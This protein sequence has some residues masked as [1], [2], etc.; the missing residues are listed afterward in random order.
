MLAGIREGFMKVF[1]LSLHTL[2]SRTE[3]DSIDYCLPL[4]FGSSCPKARS[5]S[6]SSS[7]AA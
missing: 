6:S 7:K 2:V 4:P 5:L 1:R 3:V